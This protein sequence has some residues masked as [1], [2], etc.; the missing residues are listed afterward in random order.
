MSN[1]ILTELKYRS[2]ESLLE[3]IRVDLKA[4]ANAGRIEPAQLIRQA[5]KVSYD[6]GLRINQTKQTVLEIEHNKARLP[7]DFYV[8]NFALLCGEFTLHQTLPQGTQIW[9]QDIVPTYTDWI[10]TPLCE[11]DPCRPTQ[12]P[13]SNQPVCLTKCGTGY[14]LIQKVNTQSRTYEYMYPIRFTNPRFVDC[15]CPNLQHKC[16]NEAYIRDGFVFV[17]FECG[18]LYINY[19]GALVDDQGGILVPDQPY[20]NEYYEWAL[21]VK[22]LESAFFE[23]DNTVQNML[24]LAQT[25]LRAA[26]NNALSVVNTPNFKE[27]Q[28][29]WAANRR[30][31]HMKYYQPLASWPWENQ[32]ASYGR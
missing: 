3:D 14:Q 7:E 30:A 22:V 15:D 23:G 26:R 21:K 29:T 4:F 11:T 9:E 6:L 13:L 18:N 12:W 16:A 28:D 8:M 32:L 2:F 17:N 10:D 24:Q 19:E 31:Y 5:L 27:M 20:L 25:N 1:A